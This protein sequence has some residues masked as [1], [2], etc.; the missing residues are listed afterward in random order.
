MNRLH[1][2][3]GS[4]LL[5]LIFT[6]MALTF[7]D[8][9]EAVIDS[10]APRGGE[11][12]V[13]IIAVGDSL[14]AGYGLPLSESYPAV[15]ESSLRDLGYDVEVVNSGVSGETTKGNLE[16]MNFILSQAPDVV[17]LGIG[18]NDALRLI[19]FSETEKNLRSTI[20]TLQSAE[21]AP[22]IVLL[23]MQ[24]PL[25][26]GL[27]YKREFDGLYEKLANEYGLILVPFLT[28][29]LFLEPN[30]KLPDGI[31]YNQEGYKLAVERY[32]L[33]EVKK[34]VEQLTR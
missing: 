32:I 9:N 6:V 27:S 10:I 2:I 17:I 25:T 3:I 5:L 1:I 8:S 31:H 14:T 22:V 23:K 18:G 19:P 29:E 13:K 33:P 34:V 26:S 20:T 7:T 21:N 4:V 28:T 15:L 11:S 16:R 24:A 12:A 30:N